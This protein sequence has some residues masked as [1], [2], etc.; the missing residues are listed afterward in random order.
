MKQNTLGVLA[1][2]T[3][4][5]MDNLTKETKETLA[6]HAIKNANNQRQFGAIDMWHV[7]RSQRTMTSMRKWFN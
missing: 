3:Q 4:E 2:L 6:V 1:P 7:R 5:Q